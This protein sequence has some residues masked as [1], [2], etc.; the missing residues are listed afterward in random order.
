MWHKIEVPERQE[1]SWN[2]VQLIIFIVS[3]EKLLFSFQLLLCRDNCIEFIKQ[4]SKLIPIYQCKCFHLHSVSFHTAQSKTVIRK[5]AT[6]LRECQNFVHRHLKWAAVL[7]FDYFGLGFFVYL[8]IL[9]VC[10]LSMG[11]LYLWFEIK[12][13]IILYYLAFIK[14]ILFSKEM[15][16]IASLGTLHAW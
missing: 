12:G 14:S 2:H 15:S 9:C 11:K 5:K 3:T 13:D 16:L 6:T 8:S 4:F 1:L 7:A 10:V